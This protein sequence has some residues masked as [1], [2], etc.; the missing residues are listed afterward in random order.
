M[1]ISKLLDQFLELKNLPGQNI[2]SKEKKN[3]LKLAFIL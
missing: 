1:S 2:E 3:Y